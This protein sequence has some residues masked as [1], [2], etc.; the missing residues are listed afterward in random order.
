MNNIEQSIYELLLNELIM[1]ETHYLNYAI[2]RLIRQIAGLSSNPTW[3]A[4]ERLPASV[5]KTTTQIMKFSVNTVATS[6]AR[7]GQL[8]DFIRIPNAVLETPYLLLHTRVRNLK[9]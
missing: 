7:L 8:S 9:I 3:L 6:G 5:F 2:Y 1:I 4:A